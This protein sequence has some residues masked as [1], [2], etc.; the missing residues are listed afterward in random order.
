MMFNIIPN[1]GIKHS[2]HFKTTRGYFSV[3]KTVIF[4]LE[5]ELF[6]PITGDKTRNSDW[7]WQVWLQTSLSNFVHSCSDIKS[8]WRCQHLTNAFGGM[9]ILGIDWA[10]IMSTQSS[11][12]TMKTLT[13]CKKALHLRE[14]ERGHRQVAC[15]RRHGSKMQ[16]KKMGPL[17]FLS[18]HSFTACTFT[19]HSK[20]KGCSQSYPVNQFTLRILQKNL[21][22][23]YILSNVHYGS[24]SSFFNKKILTNVW[25]NDAKVYP[26]IAS[27]L[28]L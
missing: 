18:P 10:I 6:L 7:N 27:C 15:K 21:N 26:P 17:H 12:I 24:M 25:Y 19:C 23:I 5:I 14:M 9:G 11:L 2:Q 22:Y 13:A 3:W 28:T 4:S 16:G 8:L 20:W 1:Y